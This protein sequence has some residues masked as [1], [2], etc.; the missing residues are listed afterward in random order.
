[1]LY[2]AL[3]LSFALVATGIYAM[4][5]PHSAWF[6]RIG[7]RDEPGEGRLAYIRFAGL[8]IVI[9]GLLMVVMVS[10]RLVL[11]LRNLMQ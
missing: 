7:D 11:A 6:R 1:M 9:V 8:F 3:F 10:L 4:K 2:M 5:H